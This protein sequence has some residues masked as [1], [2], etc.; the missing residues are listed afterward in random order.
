MQNSETG[1]AFSIGYFIDILFPLR[2]EIACN[3]TKNKKTV[4]Y[5]AIMGDMD[6]YQRINHDIATQK[7]YSLLEA[8][9]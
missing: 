5:T 9:L 3:N 8:I 6:G 7:L 1:H 4:I 2:E